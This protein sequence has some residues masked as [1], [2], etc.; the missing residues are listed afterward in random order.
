LP[1]RGDGATRA[2]V[3]D[4]AGELF[5][6]QGYQA[7]TIAQL[8]KAAGLSPGSGGLYRHFPSKRALLEASLKRQVD[9]GPDLAS[10]LSVPADPDD[11]RSQLLAVA[12]A[13][14]RRLRHER[15]LNRLLLR[16]LRDFPDLLAMVRDTELRRVH[17]GLARWL[18]A[19]GGPGSLDPSTVATILMGAVSHYWILSDVF[20]G[21]HPFD[22]DEEAFLGVV[23]DMAA[24]TLTAR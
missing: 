17:E 21:A 11:V 6:R 2:R 18:S 19:S 10:F 23:A 5:G 12:R 20:G 7:T 9:S 1:K 13:G 24:A 16:D 14:L 22:T 3:L 4:V 15:D 8:E